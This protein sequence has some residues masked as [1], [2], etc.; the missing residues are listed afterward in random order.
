MNYKTQANDAIDSLRDAGK[1]LPPTDRQIRELGLGYLF[2]S[3]AEA[4]KKSAKA[5]LKKL[6]L[7]PDA[8]TAG[9]KDVELVR[10]D[11]YVLKSNTAD[12]NRRLNDA[13]LRSAL[14]A[15][16]L[17][18]PAIARVMDAAYV[19]GTPGTSFVIDIR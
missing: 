6:G 8:F 13:A 16:G 1:I 18:A 4:M 12:S 7:F 2:A 3:K 11:L 17:S 15:E 19:E 5:S 10:T 9:A 14:V